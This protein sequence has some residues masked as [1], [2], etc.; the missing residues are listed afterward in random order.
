M[1]VGPAC[2]SVPTTNRLDVLRGQPVELEVVAQE[3]C[4]ASLGAHEVIGLTEDPQFVFEH[5]VKVVAL[6]NFSGV[7]WIEE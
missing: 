1:E 4:Q 7:V 3:F 2:L 6:P 5:L